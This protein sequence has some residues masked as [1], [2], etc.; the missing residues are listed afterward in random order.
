[1]FNGETHYKWPFS[2]AMLNDQRVLYLIDSAKMDKQLHPNI[3]YDISVALNMRYPINRKAIKP[4]VNQ[5]NYQKSSL[6]I[7]KS[8]IN[9][10]VY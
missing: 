8:T 1:M 2:I 5:H 10:D 9:G 4:G 3:V 6:S 7:G